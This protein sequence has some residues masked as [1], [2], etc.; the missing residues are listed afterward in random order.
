MIIPTVA[1]IGIQC[2][3]C[4]ELQFR[5]LSVFAHSHFNKESYCGACGAPLTT[6]T[7]YARGR[8]CLE[9]PC[10][11]CGE[12]HYIVVKREV[13]RR[14]SLLELSC[15]AKELPVGYVGTQNEV[16]NACQD[17]KRT[18]VQVASELVKD[19]ESE[20]EFENFYVVYAVM[21]KL[22]QMVERGQLG[23][24]CGNHNLVVEILSDRIELSCG[25]CQALGVIHTDNKDILRI[26]DRMVSIFLEESKTWFLLDSYPGHN[27]VK[28]K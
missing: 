17:L 6:L 15:P 9:Y 20:A 25:N 11:Y 2:A 22:S 7:T 8:Y 16:V 23:C 5:T 21:E 4:G 19:E 18:F 26:L 14:E 1:T 3:Q 24:R 10:I 28:N 27:L 13:M 12:T